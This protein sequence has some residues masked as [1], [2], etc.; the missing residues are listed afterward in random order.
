MYIYIYIYTHGLSLI[1]DKCLIQINCRTAA[2][3]PIIVDGQEIPMVTASAGFKVLGTQFT[4]QRKCSVELKS[5]M[6]AA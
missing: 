1:I 3:Q 5:R 4:L 2:L 6:S